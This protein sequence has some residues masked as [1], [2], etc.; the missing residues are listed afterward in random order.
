[1]RFFKH[2]TLDYFGYHKLHHNTFLIIVI[3]TFLFPVLVSSL[4]LTGGGLPFFI[5]IAPLG[6][7]IL[8]TA[9]RALD[10]LKSK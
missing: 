8:Y 1:M 2:N 7:D 5:V 6:Y 3:N 10:N 9:P 4:T